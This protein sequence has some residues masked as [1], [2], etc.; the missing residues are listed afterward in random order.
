[1]EPATQY[2]KLTKKEREKVIID[3]EKE[4]KEAAKALEFRTCSRAS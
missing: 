3:M 4:M 1:M 2:E